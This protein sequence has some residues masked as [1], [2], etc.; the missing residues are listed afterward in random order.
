MLLRQLRTLFSGQPSARGV[1][2]A[3]QTGTRIGPGRNWSLR[4]Q[5][6]EEPGYRWGHAGYDL[7][8]FCD[9]R[10]L[11]YARGRDELNWNQ[12]HTLALSDTK[13]LLWRHVSHGRAGGSAR[14]HILLQHHLAHDP[15]H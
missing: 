6:T 10:A 9:C 15:G 4:F 5:R 12:C 2:P 13:S 8:S 11:E 7:Q 1:Q 3:H 14:W